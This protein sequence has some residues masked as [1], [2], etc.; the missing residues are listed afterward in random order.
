MRYKKKPLTVDAIQIKENITIEIGGKRYKVYKGDF[1]VQDENGEL[2]ILSEKEFAD[3]YVL[4]NEEPKLIPYPY[5][6]T[7]PNI[8]IDPYY[9]TTTWTYSP[10]NTIDKQANKFVGQDYINNQA[11]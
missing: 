6:P 10:I 8:P 3:E 7:T 2:S 4:D 5:I 11:Q 1:L 9:P